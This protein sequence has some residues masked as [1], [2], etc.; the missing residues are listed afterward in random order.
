MD[1][2]FIYVIIIVAV[3]LAF[4]YVNGFHDAANAV[5]TV[6]ATR[7]LSPGVAVVYAAALNFAAAFWGN[8]AVSG[9]FAKGIVNNDEIGRLLTAAGRGGSSEVFFASIVLCALLGAIIWNIVTWLMGLPSSSSH[10]LIGG[11]IGS[12]LTG[13]MIILHTIHGVIYWLKIAQ[14]CAFIVIAPCAGMFLGY[15]LMIFMMWILR[16]QGPFTV[17]KLFRKIQLLSSGAYSFSHGSNDAQKTM[18]IILFLLISAGKLPADV[19]PDNIWYD[20]IMFGCFG[21]IAAGTL[22][23]GWKIVK[24][25]GLNITKLKPVNGFCAE[26]S[27]AISILTASHLGIPVSTTHVITGAIV[28]VGSV[29]RFSAVRWGVAGRIVWAWV[30]TIPAAAIVGALAFVIV[31]PIV[32]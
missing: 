31:W 18:G 22:S 7:V 32:F 25:M 4:D 14:I 17:D 11:F 3:A 21:C 30:V 23:G 15:F 2:F 6:I 13:C 5:S 28:G 29:R 20:L 12:V 16:R 9:T 19:G 24:T 27:G 8:H 26:V 1:P 10:A